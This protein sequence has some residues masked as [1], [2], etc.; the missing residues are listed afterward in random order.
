MKW[1]PAGW[2]DRWGGG[3]LWLAGGA[4][5][6]SLALVLALVGWPL[7]AAPETAALDPVV[8]VIPFPSETLTPQPTGTA[9]PTREP[10]ASPTPPPALGSFSPGQ[11]VQIVG[12]QGDGLRL[13]SSPGLDG[14]ILVLGLENEVFEVQDGPQQVDGYTW[15]FLVNPYDNSKRGWGVANYI[16]ASEGS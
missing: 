6:G 14:E 10:T 11:L 5:V 15:W 7:L 16:R 9:D 3:C 2:V 1:I 13:R 8:S 4:L 12:T